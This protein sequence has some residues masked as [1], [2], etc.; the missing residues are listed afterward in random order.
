MQCNEGNMEGKS[1]P[2][3]D[4]TNDKWQIEV[5]R[6]FLVFD[7]IPS[8]LVTW[9]TTNEYIRAFILS[10]ICLFMHPWCLCLYVFPVYSMLSM[11][12]EDFPCFSCFF[13]VFLSFWAS[14]VVFIFV[15]SFGSDVSWLNEESSFYRHVYLKSFVN[16]W[17]EKKSHG[18]NITWHT[19]HG[20]Q[21]SGQINT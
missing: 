9:Q 15:F 13:V 14:L 10:F 11:E 19:G 1:N 18:M 7:S 2:G 5:G 12:L 20:T 3:M 4:L 16:T 8:S 21:M 17:R 6:N